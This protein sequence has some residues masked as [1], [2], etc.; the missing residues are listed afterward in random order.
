[1]PCPAVLQTLASYASNLL[2]APFAILCKMSTQPESSLT[3][4]VAENVKTLV[5]LAQRE[6]RPIHRLPRGFSLRTLAHAR[7]ATHSMTLRTLQRLAAAFGL[8]PWQL[9]LPD[10]PAELALD[11]R[12]AQTVR[13]YIA[14]NAGG[15]KAIEA[16][17]ASVPKR[18]G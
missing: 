4:V 10:L 1:M 8:E 13:A 3:A 6:G 12:L 16:V 17:A 14:A 7:G 5:D 18:A 2:R 9:L 11:K 15:Q